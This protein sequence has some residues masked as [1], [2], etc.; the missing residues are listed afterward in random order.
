MKT[1]KTLRRPAITLA[2]V[3]IL[4]TVAGCGSG[5]WTGT[6][7]PPDDPAGNIYVHDDADSRT[8]FLIATSRQHLRAR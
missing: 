8:G 4:M 1:W 2:L 6:Y 7:V 5:D 3:V